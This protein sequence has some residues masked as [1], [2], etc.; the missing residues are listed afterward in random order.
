M[1]RSATSSDLDAI[2]AVE[3]TDLVSPLDPARVREDLALHRHRPEWV[4]VADEHGRL[5]AFALWW[6]LPDSAQPA[7]LTHIWVSPDVSASADIAGG[8]LEAAVRQLRLD[9]LTTM[10]EAELDLPA[11]WDNDADT[12][13]AV[14]WR[15]AAFERIGLIDW[16]ERRQQEWTTDCPLPTDSGRLDYSRA[17][18]EAFLDVF[19][20]VAVGSLDVLT[21]RTLAE[22]G[23]DG[24]AQDDLDFYLSLPGDRTLWR[25]AT[26]QDGAVIGF[27]IPSRSAYE[28]SV[29]YLGVTPEQRGRR[30]VDD[31]LAE[32]TRIHAATG[33]TRIT[34]TTDST[35]APMLAAFARAGYTTI[36]T[37]LVGTEPA[38]HN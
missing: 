36:G 17:S 33:A 24:Q 20:R 37:R 2:L 35:N 29:S 1:F 16:N 32:I 38:S 14:K 10:P 5:T 27:A 11:D 22:L 21:R 18:D 7:S 30:Y 4:W 19:R 23:P 3:S 9:G 13:A 28:A 12:R 25:L 15:Q 8:L 31:L 26:D 6:G 34:G